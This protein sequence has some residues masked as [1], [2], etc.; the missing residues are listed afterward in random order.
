[1]AKND[2]WTI[3]QAAVA[4]YEYCRR[5][6][7]QFS[8]RNKF[9]QDLSV[10]INRSP[11]AIVRKIGNFAS[12][13]PQMKA[14][15][16]KGLSHTAKLDEVLWDKYYGHWDQ[17]AIDAELI[18]ADFKNVDLEHSVTIDLNNLPVGGERFQ[19]VKS[20][21]NQAFFR[22][23]VLSS[24]G[25]RCCITGLNNPSLLQACHIVSW[26]DEPEIRTNPENGLCLNVLLH[27]AYDEYLIGIDTDYKIHVSDEFFG[28][29]LL[30]VDK[31]VRDYYKAINGKKTIF[32][33]MRFSPNVDLLDMHFQKYLEKHA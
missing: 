19:I 17:L 13:D 6:F 32:M 33:P 2:K 10:L 9:V 22:D 15:G 5:P 30:N 8:S 29:N 28:T 20:R 18:I 23:A 24:Y 1:M 12:F 7:G 16:V 14:R 31:E 25:L 21:I 27:K 26:K 3:E 11:G 4:L